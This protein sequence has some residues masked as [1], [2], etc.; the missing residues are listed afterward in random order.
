MELAL[1]PG[2]AEAFMLAFARVGA[3]VM[4]MPGLGERA[5]PMRQRLV[6]ALA[7]TLMALPLLRE[8]GGGG[9]PAPMRFVS[10]IITGLVLGL[11]GR[12]T[13][14]VLD[15]A[16]TLIAQSV[17][18]SFAQVM[19]PANGQQ[20]EAITSF[21]R[22]FGVCLIFATDLH[23]LAITGIF[24]SYEVV[25]PGQGLAAG[26]M[27]TLVLQL[28]TRL[29]EAGVLIAA[30]FVAFSFIFNL[31]LGLAARL[32]PQLQLF[33]LSMPAAILLGLMAFSASLGAIG[34][35][36]LDVMRAALALPFG[37]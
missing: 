7:L 15:V 4:L 9:T 6:I 28:V 17:G 5:I 31:G 34:R 27:A 30:P 14:A 3:M 20:G 33:Y 16:G 25:A 11:A 12:L 32:T 37:G 19:D 8:A 2:F 13:M 1:A 10:E 35:T 29:F 36:F 26:D 24:A 18:L 21:L 22:I 23:H